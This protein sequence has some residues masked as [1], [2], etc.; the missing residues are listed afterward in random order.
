M[1]EAFDIHCP[2]TYGIGLFLTI[3]PEDKDEQIYF[4]V[5]LGG[6]FLCMLVKNQAG[7]WECIDGEHPDEVDFGFIT[8]QIDSNL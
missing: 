5:Q 6:E 3:V 4:E 8:S 1:M 2:N 7:E